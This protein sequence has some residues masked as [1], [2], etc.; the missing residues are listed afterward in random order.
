MLREITKTESYI[1]KVT[2]FEKHQKIETEWISCQTVSQA[3]YRDIRKPSCQ[4]GQIQGIKGPFVG[5]TDTQWRVRSLSLLKPVH[6]NPAYLL[7]KLQE[8][9]KKSFCTKVSIFVRWKS[10]FPTLLIIDRTQTENFPTS[11]TV[12]QPASH[13]YYII[14]Q[15]RFPFVFKMNRSSI[16]KWRRVLT[17]SSVNENVVYKNAVSRFSPEMGRSKVR[18]VIYSPVWPF[19]SHLCLRRR[20]Y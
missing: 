7:L 2:I 14:S 17:F 15:Y 1:L 20:L 9:V 18:H 11:G 13:I 3:Y 8:F 5:R 10:L 4:F 6:S 12:S 19:Y 16:W